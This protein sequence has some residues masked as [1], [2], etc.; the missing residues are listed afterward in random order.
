[1]RTLIG[2]ALLVATAGATAQD[3]PWT[4]YGDLRLR[5]E[6]TADI[7]AR[8]DDIERLRS[9]L[10]AGARYNNEN[11]FEFAAAGKLGVG[12]DDNADNIRNLDNERSDSGGID[13]LYVAWAASESTRFQLGKGRNPFVTTPLTWDRDLRPIGAYVEYQ[14]S[15]RDFDAF[16][17]TG[18]YFA[19]D[20][21]YSDDSKIAGLQIGYGWM[22]GAESG[23]ST[24]LGY[25][26]YSDLDRAARSGL[27]RTNRRV[28]NRFVSDFD[29][30]NWQLIG[31]L[32]LAEKPLVTRLDLVRNLGADDLRD[33]ARFSAI[34][35][36]AEGL[37]GW[38]V[39]YSY[40]RPQRDAVLAY[41]AEDDWWFHSFARGYM[42][43]VA[44]GFERGIS[45]QLSG[46]VERRDLLDDTTKR[47]LLDV[48]KRW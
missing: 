32:Q 44:Y 16:Y 8:S 21:L 19:G 34:W 38:E 22:E 39:G 1:M 24:F 4:Y 3:S 23:F 20:H 31:R 46:F 2:V 35:G 30:L 12:S 6:K 42:P 25:F 33:G 40:Q 43:W 28:N 9:F 7:P 47:L 14:T 37:G 41:F 29:L 10:R 18:G 15:V 13:E 11:G 27:G 17:F 48:R 45:V 5:A 26:D 36:D